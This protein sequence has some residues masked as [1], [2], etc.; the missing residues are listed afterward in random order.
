MPPEVT[1]RRLESLERAWLAEMVAGLTPA[2]GEALGLALTDTDV[3]TVVSLRAFPT[4]RDFNRTLNLGLQRAV[5]DAALDDLLAA[6]RRQG[7][8]QLMVGLLP[9]AQPADL[10]G[11]LL[12]RGAQPT[13][14]WMQLWRVPGSPHVPRAGLEGVLDV[15][16]VGADEQTTFVEVL[17]RGMGMPPALGALPRSLFGRAGWTHY[18]AWSGES[19]VACASLY[20]RG[21][22][23][24]FGA[25]ATLPEH[26]RR[27]AQQALIAR[28]LADAAQAGARLCSTQVAEDLPGRPNPSEHNMRRAGFQTAYR[29]EHLLVPTE[30]SAS[31][32]GDSGP[33]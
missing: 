12:R 15:R 33:A 1:P 27:G 10:R 8:L 21:E 28:R 19:A 4:I 18:L 23:A 31:P 25:A 17:T 30:G 22:D 24:W 26:R 9:G 11:R 29:R 6:T 7:L 3:G 13:R 20:L 32:A 16:T 2:D 5:T 14:A